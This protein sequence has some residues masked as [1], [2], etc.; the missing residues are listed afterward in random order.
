M[1]EPK[2]ITERNE[3]FK[4]SEPHTAKKQTTSPKPRHGY[5]FLDKPDKELCPCA[6]LWVTK[7][8]NGIGPGTVK[9]LLIIGETG[10][11]KESGKRMG[12]SYSKAWK[13]IAKLEAQLGTPPLHLQQG[14]AHGGGASLTNAG[15]EFVEKYEQ[16]R[17]EAT[18]CVNEL[19]VKYFGEQ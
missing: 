17:T 5:Y 14:G 8:G 1:S 6:K 11:V 19:F 18:D 7:D 16:F 13:L 9:L 4:T 2:N 15:K 3:F 10:S 12:M